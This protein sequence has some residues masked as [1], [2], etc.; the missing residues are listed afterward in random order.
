MEA[1]IQAGRTG[2]L[3]IQW[4]IG[5]PERS[6]MDSLRKEFLAVEE[7]WRKVGEEAE[8]WGKSLEAV[9]PEMEEFQVGVV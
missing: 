5:T 3:E 8:E 2:L 7:R 4:P 6:R 1:V 9:H